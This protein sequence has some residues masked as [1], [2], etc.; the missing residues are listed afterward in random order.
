MSIL[1]RE[2]LMA[3]AS[4]GELPRVRVEVPE[5]GGFVWVRG[6]SGIERD[7]W[8]KALVVRRRDGSVNVK[9]ENL[10][11]RLA[12]K[13]LVD[14]F[15]TALLQ[16]GDAQVL[17][18]LRVD[19]LQRIFNEAQKLSG[20]SDEDLDDLKKDSGA[21]DGSVSSSSSLSASE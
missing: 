15:G 5:L 11:A 9:S 16:D 19:V 8:E 4:S 2:A 13:V 10:R 12:A 14:E 20:F 17:G 1:N 18:G 3:A 7:A 6:M 21:E